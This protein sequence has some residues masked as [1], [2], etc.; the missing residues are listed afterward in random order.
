MADKILIFGEVSPNGIKTIT[1]ECISAVKNL[2]KNEEIIVLLCGD[3]LQLY[4]EELLYYG[5]DK[6]LMV[7]NTKLTR[8]SPQTYNQVIWH[9]QKEVNPT[10]T[11]FGHT[12]IGKAVTPYLSEKANIP[13][14]SNIDSLNIEGTNIMV[15]RPAYSGK[16]TE[17]LALVKGSYI[18]TV[19]P[20]IWTP[21]PRNEQATGTIHS[22]N[23]IIEEP[24]YF[25]KERI[26]KEGKSEGL[27]EAKIII[28]AGRGVQN[29]EGF[30]L[31]QQLANTLG[32]TVGVS[33]GA[34]ELGVSDSSLQIGQTGKI[35]APDIYIA[36]GISGAIQHLV[37]VTSAKTI[38]AINNDPN[39]PIFDVADYGLVGDLFEIIPALIEEL[40]EIG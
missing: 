9:V 22:K 7:E 25:L 20:K 27:N 35:I 32:G 8:F 13:L 3:K 30:S 33:R 2:Y 18:F 29:K 38:I 37:G 19:K 1:L 23:V 26:K 10:L 12:E 15:S 16:L 39:A 4:A 11:V 6:V 5:I 17:Q 36:C 14:I 24:I 40:E 31:L 28:G 21:F 34:V